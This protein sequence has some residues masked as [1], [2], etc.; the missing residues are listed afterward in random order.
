MGAPITSLA[1]SFD[2]VYAAAGSYIGRYVRGKEVGRFV[3][4]TSSPSSASSSSSGS[5]SDSDSDM[6]DD[7]PLAPTITHLTLFGTTLV[8]LSLDGR[9]MFVWDVPAI[10]N[11][12]SVK[13]PTASTSA[14]TTPYATIDFAPGFTASKIVHPASYLNKVVVGSREGA[15]AVWNVRTACVFHWLPAQGHRG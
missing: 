11:P 10:V 7:S 3:L 4:S 2:S 15:L 14:G 5:D 9:K 6:D 1:I 8:A 12:A 13:E